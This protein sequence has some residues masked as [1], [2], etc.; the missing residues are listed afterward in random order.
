M[1]A[2]MTTIATLPRRPE[3]LHWRSI[4]ISR[5]TNEKNRLLAALPIEEYWRLAPHF[6]VLKLD[7]RQVLASPEQPMRHVFF[8]RTGVSAMLVPMEDGSAAEG[9]TVGNEGMIGLPVFLGEPTASEEIVQAIPGEAV[10]LRASIFK[11]AVQRSPRF[12]TVLQRYTLAL[13][14]QMI[15][16]AGC[17]RVHAVDQRCARLLLMSCDRVGSD[18]F[19]VTHEFLATVLS[20][21][22]ASLTE[23]AGMLQHAG[24]IEYRRGQMRI[25]DRDGLEEVACEDYRLARDGYDRLY[26]SHPQFV[27]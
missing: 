20:V 4:P 14:N 1:E 13:M 3:M 16:T 25:C 23:A 5:T 10:R 21:R 27:A 6:E 12:Q 11:E 26:D 2:M 15:R 24:L 18:A 8:P 19:P 22:R 17:N 9:A 7:A